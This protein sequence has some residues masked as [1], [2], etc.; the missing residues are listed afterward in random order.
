MPWI[1]QLNKVGVL[2]LLVESRGRHV[3]QFFQVATRTIGGSQVRVIQAKSVNA[4]DGFLSG[5]GVVVVGVFFPFLQALEGQAQRCQKGVCPCTLVGIRQALPR[6]AGMVA[7]QTGT[8]GSLAK[9]G[10]E[11]Q[12]SQ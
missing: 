11:Q 5:L 9:N 12:T 2:N 3:Q 10:Q 6:H 7:K 8:L 4:D 1:L